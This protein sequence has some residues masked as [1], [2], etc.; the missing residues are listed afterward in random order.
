MLCYNVQLCTNLSFLGT[1]FFFFCL[2]RHS[3]NEII[4]YSSYCTFIPGLQTFAIFTS[5]NDKILDLLVTRTRETFSVY[6]LQILHLY[7]TSVRKDI[8][9][10]SEDN[11]VLLEFSG[12]KILLTGL[13]FKLY[14]ACNYILKGLLKVKCFQFVLEMDSLADTEWW[15]WQ[16]QLQLK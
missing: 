13:V 4:K 15:Y 12:E 7:L 9:V 16:K 3:Y 14:G 6:Y 2:C 5:Q 10:I 1:L 11:L 8:C